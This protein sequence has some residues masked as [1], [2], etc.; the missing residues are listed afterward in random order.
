MGSCR[1]NISWQAFGYF[2]S[3]MP[4]SQ[5]VQAVF[6][7]GL[8]HWDIHWLPCH[9]PPCGWHRQGASS[10][11]TPLHLPAGKM[12]LC[13]LYQLVQAALTCVEK[14]NQKRKSYLHFQP[15]SRHSPCMPHTQA[16]LLAPTQHA[17]NLITKVWLELLKGS[18][19]WII[20]F[21][22]ASYLW[23][24]LGNC[25]YNALFSCR[26]LLSLFHAKKGGKNL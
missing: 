2:R 18:W 4:R 21:H 17:P 1:I 19:R 5:V 20:S 25:L 23:K 11:I 26:I 16:L 6:K 22:S 7:P 3:I 24:F 9:S 14:P 12:A 15:D 8:W 10:I 13:S